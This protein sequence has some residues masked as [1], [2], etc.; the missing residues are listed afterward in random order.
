[1]TTTSTSAAICCGCG[2]RAHD[3]TSVEEQ[4]RA[5]IPHTAHGR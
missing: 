2:S 4:L 3:F 1:M 5:G